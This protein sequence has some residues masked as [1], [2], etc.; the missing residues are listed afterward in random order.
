VKQAGKSMNQLL[1][2]TLKSVKLANYWC[3]MVFWQRHA[4]LYRSF[5]SV[6]EHTEWKTRIRD[7][8]LHDLRHVLAS[9]L[10]MAEVGVPRVKASLGH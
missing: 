2:D 4:V 5:Y 10:A 9:Y 3:V 7:L 1:T 8:L 6:F